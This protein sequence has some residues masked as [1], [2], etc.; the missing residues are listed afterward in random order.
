MFAYYSR[1]N[2]LWD[3]LCIPGIELT[4]GGKPLQR[5]FP[6]IKGYHFTGIQFRHAFLQFITRFPQ[7]GPGW[8]E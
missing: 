7:P 1:V 3:D 8:R 2:P 6:G 4:C 5:G